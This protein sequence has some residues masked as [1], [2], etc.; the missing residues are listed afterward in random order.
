MYNQRPPAESRYPQFRF[1]RELDCLAPKPGRDLGTLTFFNNN[2]QES[3][4]LRVI[5][6]ATRDAMSFRGVATN[7]NRTRI[8]N[9]HLRGNFTDL[10]VD[11]PYSPYDNEVEIDYENFSIDPPCDKT[12]FFITNAK[13][14]YTRVASERGQDPDGALIKMTPEAGENITAYISGIKRGWCPILT[15]AVA[16]AVTIPV[17]TNTRPNVKIRMTVKARSVE[18]DISVETGSGPATA[19]LCCSGDRRLHQRR[20]TRR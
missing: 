5:E 4:L 18:A 9:F 10:L 17:V 2:N 3:L 16:P 13:V 14:I 11:L 1:A 8:L 15:V 12:D 6:G 19:P 7:F 20:R